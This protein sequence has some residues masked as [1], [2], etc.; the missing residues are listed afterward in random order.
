MSNIFFYVKIL[1][2]A[3]CK[4]LRMKGGC[5]MSTTNNSSSF[6]GMRVVTDLGSLAIIK[7]KYVIEPSFNGL[8]C[9]YYDRN[10]FPK[11]KPIRIDCEFFKEGCTQ[12]NIALQIKRNLK[13]KKKKLCIS[14]SAVKAIKRYCSN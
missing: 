14:K 6:Y 1:F 3:L 12:K 13:K 4:A 9:R 10:A 2:E 8:V 7:G 11:G 5:K